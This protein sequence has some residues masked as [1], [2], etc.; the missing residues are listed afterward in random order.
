MPA[1]S[2]DENLQVQ[3]LHQIYPSVIKPSFNSSF[4]QKSYF[5]YTSSF[6]EFFSPYD[7]LLDIDARL[8]YPN[9]DTVLKVVLILINQKSLH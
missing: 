1:D 3:I 8:N 9:R 2:G 7:H 4:S 6:N 5:K